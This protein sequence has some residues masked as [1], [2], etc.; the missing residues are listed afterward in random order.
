M[1]LGVKSLCDNR[2]GPSCEASGRSV[3]DTEALAS[4]LTSASRVQISGIKIA[5]VRCVEA[6]PS[7]ASG[8][9]PACR[10]AP[11]GRCV[12]RAACAWRSTSVYIIE[13][14]GPNLF[15]C[16][17]FVRDSFGRY[18]PDRTDAC[19]SSVTSQPGASSSVTSQPGASSF[20]CELFLVTASQLTCDQL[21]CDQLTWDQLTW[22]QLTWDQQ[23]LSGPSMARSLVDSVNL[24]LGPIGATL[25]SSG[26][27]RKRFN[28]VRVVSRNNKKPRWLTA[29]RAQTASSRRC[30][31]REICVR[32]DV[33]VDQRSWRRTQTFCQSP[34]EP[35]V[36]STP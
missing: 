23:R 18:S 14:F 30:G 12:T 24:T 9:G 25:S 8:A 2:C 20:F 13:V 29:S 11:M 27:S 36:E 3:G 19:T 33:K 5:S 7:S 15:E 1:F 22:D 4:R 10:R 16:K 31:D 21:T 28:E 6:G 34:Q 26:V 32:F 35:R 17:R